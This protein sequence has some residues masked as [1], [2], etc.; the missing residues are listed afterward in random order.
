M[1]VVFISIY[2]LF[3]TLLNM[4]LFNTR[5]VLG[6]HLRAHDSC[7]VPYNAVIRNFIRKCSADVTLMLRFYE[8]ELDNTLTGEI[9]GQPFIMFKKNYISREN[10]FV[11]ELPLILIFHFAYA[12]T[13]CSFF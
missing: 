3:R 6:P 9:V 13:C 2:G 10:S 8:V 4:L 11:R 12:D 1:I 5:S 7:H